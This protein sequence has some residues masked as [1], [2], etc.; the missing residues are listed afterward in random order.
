MVRER[1]TAMR[2]DADRLDVGSDDAVAFDAA[3]TAPIDA[4]PFTDATPIDATGY[5]AGLG[6][7]QNGNQAREEARA[8]D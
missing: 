8:R 4:S 2:S 3:E 5:P 1:M 6:I 7:D